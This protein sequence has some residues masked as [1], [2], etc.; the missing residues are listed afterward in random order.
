[1][2]TNQFVFLDT[3]TTGLDKAFHQPVEIGGVVTDIQLSPLRQFELLCRPS[4]FVL[5]DPKA[6]AVTGRSIGE[7]MGRGCSTYEVT[8]RFADEVR[9][10]AGGC[11]VTYNGIAFDDPMIEHT[12]YRN[13]HDPYC[14]KK[15][16]SRI[17][18]LHVVH[19]VHV[20]A[21]G[22]LVVPNDVNGLPIFKLDVLGPSNGFNENGAHT[23]CVDARATLHLVRRVAAQAPA[24]W[25]RAVHLWAR[26][27]AVRELLTSSD[28]VVLFEW[29][30]KSRKPHFKALVPVGPRRGYAGEFLCLDT[31]IDP[32]SYVSLP[33]SELADK[34]TCGTVHRPVCPVRLNKMPIIFAID[35]PLIA[36]HIPRNVMELVGRVRPLLSDIDFCD[37]MMKAADLRQ[38]RFPESPHVE[39]QLYSGG[40]ISDADAAKLAEFHRAEPR[41]KMDIVAYINDARLRKLATRVVYEE[42]PAALSAATREHLDVEVSARLHA[43]DA[44]PWTTFA[45]AFRD[46]EKLMPTANEKSEAILREYRQ[47]LVDIS[48]IAHAAQ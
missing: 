19:A 25:H 10:V 41:L 18:M 32:S 22:T 1:M 43:S 2:S 21:P 6:L 42:W 31:A 29:N 27:N 16:A 40:F 4:C 34:I 35:D 46:I 47:Y 8:R 14:M 13:L 15:A 28:V 12:L 39:Q 44:S 3:E 11:F 36:K 30:A 48:S 38:D 9:N 23:A 20:L 45:S 33:S 5:P 26:K 17:D 7:L 37:R 24:I